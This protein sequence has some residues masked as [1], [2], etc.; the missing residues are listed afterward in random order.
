V[1]ARLSGT[2]WGSHGGDMP[3][4]RLS[5]AGFDAHNPE[6][7]RLRDLVGSVME[8]PAISRSMSAAS[9]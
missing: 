7:A 8:F 1:T 4:K 5:E 2:I 6:L 9:C 3:E